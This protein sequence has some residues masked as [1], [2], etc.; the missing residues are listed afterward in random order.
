MSRPRYDWWSYIKAVIR[1]Y[2]RLKAEYQD[3]H[4]Q[5]MTAHY[6]GMPRSGAAVRTT[7]QLAIRQLPTNKQREYEAVRL[8][9]ESTERMTGGLDRLKIIDLVLWRRSHTLE[10][11]AL[12][13]PCST[14]TAWRWHGEFIRLVAGYMGFL[15]T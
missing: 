1:K 11:A 14:S 10:G 5:A 8:A 12:M 3:L 6:S 7:E 13:I 2:P 9:I 15:D 4:N